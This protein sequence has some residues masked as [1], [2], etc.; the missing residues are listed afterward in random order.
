M[1]THFRGADQIKKIKIRWFSIR[2]GKRR[3]YELVVERSE[4][5]PEKESVV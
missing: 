2:H 3:I 4:D 5:R 1:A